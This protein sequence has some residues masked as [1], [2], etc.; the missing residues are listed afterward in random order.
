MMNH[1]HLLSIIAI[2]TV[3][4][5][6]I[7][8]V[9][10]KKDGDTNSSTDA[11]VVVYGKI[12]TAENDTATFAEAFVVKGRKFVY[13]GSK[14]EAAKY[15]GSK[16]QVLNYTDKGLIIPGCTEGHGH[17]IGID[18][19]ARMFPGFRASY[20]ELVGSIIP[21]AMASK[22]RR[23]ITFGWNTPDVAKYSQRDYASELE[24][25]SCGYPVILY[26][27]GGHNAICNRTA[28]KCA[29]LI[30]DNGEIIRQV[31][32]GEIVPIMDNA[33]N[34]T[35]IA[36]GYITDEI[37][38]YV[39]EKAFGSI[40]NDAQYRQAC[41]NAVRSLN[42]RGFT[43][44]LDAYINVF[45]N[46]EA[47]RF[48]SDLD[49][50]GQLTVNMMGYYTIRSY[51]WGFP[52]GGSMPV[53]VSKKLDFVASLASK[54]STPHVIVNGVKLFADGVTEA[55][56]GWISGEYTMEGLPTDRR[57]GNIIWDQEELNQIVAAS[58]AKGFPVHV[59]TFGDMAC[60]AVINAFCA[61]P[62]SANLNVR[63]SLAHVRN[64]SQADITRCGQNNIG[65]ASNI[66]WHAAD[67]EEARQYILS[68]VPANI[69]E[70]GYPMKSLM[71][72]GIVV[73]SS[74]DAPCGEN[75]IGTV[76]NII[77][78]GV[79]GLYPSTASAPPLNPTEL[80][81]VNQVLKC[82]TINGAAS[83]GLEQERGSIKVGKYADFVLLDKDLFEL[84][85]TNKLDIF[86]T[87]VQST[88]F[89]GKK[90][91]QR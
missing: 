71:N 68:Y 61:S 43:S 1:K 44:Y 51:D 29:G 66:I 14:A 3:V 45:D 42:E 28:L 33:G 59:H 56:T 32:G 54:Y 62:S 52:R 60:N 76:P 78:V 19:I 22:P 40:L 27:C 53:S 65:I 77:G 48:V 18:A 6:S 90:V 73:S 82:L 10:C 5:A 12:Y 30:N 23:I 88:W 21:Q 85:R 70:S 75:L 20:S 25:V 79:T 58:N 91:Y 74:T 17:F 46:A 4:V 69:Y 84:E 50:A 24:A 39:T 72:A 8:Y 16:T 89:E 26:D 87:N 55:A 9:S 37:A 15:I 41:I 13:V 11:D 7:L 36:N 47:Y 49:R 31:R 86:N 64:I 83:L 81:T 80:L 57:H 63:N 38:G 67:L 34:P 2:A 35:N